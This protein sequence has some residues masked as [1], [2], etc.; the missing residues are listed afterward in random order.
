MKIVVCLTQVPD[1]ESKF[2]IIDDS[3]VDESQI[4]FKINDF[5]NYAVEAALQLREK[6]GGEVIIVTAGGA[7][8][9]EYAVGERPYLSEAV[10]ATFDPARPLTV[11]E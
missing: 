10:E 1:M 2:K 5:D 7:T 9:A 3:K 6:A 8:V 11:G 4:A